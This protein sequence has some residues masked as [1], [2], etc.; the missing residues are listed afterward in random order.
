[1][2]A[3]LF[4]SSANEP[5]IGCGT[6]HTCSSPLLEPLLK[7]AIQGMRRSSTTFLF[8]LLLADGRFNGFYEPLAAARKPAVGGGSKISSTD[9]FEN[10]RAAREAFQPGAHEAG[11]LNW[12]APIDPDREIDAALPPLVARY[13][14]FLFAQSE[15]SLLKFVRAYSKVPAL[16]QVEPDLILIHIVRDPRAVVTSF[17]FG[18]G[19][20]HADL[21]TDSSS[22]FEFRGETPGPRHLQG[23]EL[24]DRLIE[25]NLVECPADAPSFMKL[26]A[27][28]GFHYA[29]TSRDLPPHALTLRHEELLRDPS[30]SLDRID[31]VLDSP[32]TDDARTWL[33]THLD[34]R[35][36]I[37][38]PT[39]PHWHHALL[40]LRLDKVLCDAG[41]A[42]VLAS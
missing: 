4:S 2:N 37:F 32:L 34:P 8:D 20:R 3:L 11:L 35:Q 21:F 38:E 30:G 13:I 42:S 15:H 29:S 25:R 22:F 18:K 7:I 24:A 26:L 40:E 28:W 6:I 12:G 19:R 31:A 41:Y 14:R 36:R 33:D 1:M 10:I 23:L 39:N 9:F 5:R 16:L 17:L 27:L